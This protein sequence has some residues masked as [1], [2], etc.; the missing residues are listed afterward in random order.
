MI[1]VYNKKKLEINIINY[2]LINEIVNF[3]NHKTVRNQKQHFRLF[4]LHQ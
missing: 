2:I 1:I 4:L 3:L